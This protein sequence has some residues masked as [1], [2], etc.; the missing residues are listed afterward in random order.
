MDPPSYTLAFWINYACK[1]VIFYYIE[2]K[3]QQDL[4]KK[5]INSLFAT[6]LVL[7]LAISSIEGCNRR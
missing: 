6:I 7:N 4:R 5:T 2:I 3:C 1:M